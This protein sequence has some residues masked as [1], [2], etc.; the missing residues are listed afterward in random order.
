MKTQLI[1]AIISSVIGISCFIPYIR[2]IFKGT[3]KPHSY[4]WLIWTI[5]QTIGVV[6]M[7]KGG[8]GIGV[9][10]LS[11]GALLCGFIFILS[12][13]YG[14]TNIK[15]FDKICL[16]GA[17]FAIAAYFFFENSLISILI[18]TITDIIGFLPT[19]RKSYEE[20]NTETASS[21]GFS[22][23]A[24]FFSLLALSVF[25]LTTSLY[26]I[27]LIITN[28]LCAFIILKSRKRVLIFEKLKVVPN[29]SYF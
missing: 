14:T 3:T 6:A 15:L 28:G 25:T 5:L 8:A 18:I 27:T 16:T 1:F 4:S 19:F 26:L 24:S 21:Y 11:V 10:H 17:L 13:K 20:P 12:L 23:I 7:I 22:V 2:D 29:K 9:A